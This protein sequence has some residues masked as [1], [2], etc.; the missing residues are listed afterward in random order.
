MYRNAKKENEWN[1]RGRQHNTTCMD[2]RMLP[3]GIR[4]MASIFV[5]ANAVPNN[6]PTKQP[7]SAE[8][9]EFRREK[10]M[11]G[12]RTEQNRTERNRAERILHRMERNSSQYA[13]SSQVDTNC[14]PL[15]GVATSNSATSN[16]Y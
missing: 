10:G 12:K 3:C 1:I 9:V 7:T 5:E 16:Y 8:E 4:N 15:N 14:T 11:V 6:Q 2:T 13:K